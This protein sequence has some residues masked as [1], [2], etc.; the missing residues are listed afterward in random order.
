MKKT[1]IFL[2]LLCILVSLTNCA[3][4]DF[5]ERDALDEELVFTGF[6]S[7]R[8]FL[9]NIYS[10][11]PRMD[12]YLDRGAML[13]C[14]TDDA[15]YVND[16]SAVQRFNSGNITK[17]YNPD[18]QWKNMYTG[19]RKCNLFLEK[20]TINTL[21][22]YK[23]NND[24]DRDGDQYYPK[25]IKS[26]EYQRAE[27]RFL[28]AF[29]YFE[30]IKRYGGVPIIKDLGI[31]IGADE[32][33]VHRDS[34]SDCLNFIIS[35]LNGVIPLLPVVH[36]NSDGLQSQTGRATKGAAM[37]LKSRALLYA[38]SP[39]FNTSGN[40][41]LWRQAITA[42]DDILKSDLY[43]LESN[44]DD[45]FLKSNSTELIL[46]RRLADSNNFER[47]N[48]PI[49]FYVGNTGTCPSQNLVYSYEMH[50]T[51]LGIHVVGS[52]YNENDHTVVEIR[53]YA[54]IDYNNA[55]WAS[56]NIEIWQGGKDAP[57][58]QNATKTGYYLKNT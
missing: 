21:D 57:P 6:S 47:N 32:F 26:L 11:L 2:I 40:T 20:A 9:Y 7:Q 39:L 4:L 14:V 34:F 45:L 46:E 17:F 1:N 28:R 51:G 30:L 42:A 38:A 29:F 22:E 36:D 13:A 49:V 52:G 43:S 31:D 33:N 53:F 19:I 35:E 8:N 50:I 27:A 3:N 5:D 24:P 54:T 10:S 55:L 37:A 41:D 18:D 56:R 16:F 44:Y 25:L 12:N 48:Y 58:I 15:E 23:T